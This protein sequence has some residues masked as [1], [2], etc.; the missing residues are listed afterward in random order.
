MAQVKVW[1]DNVHDYKE[2]FRERDIVIKAKQYVLMDRDEAEIFQGTYNGRMKDHGDQDDPKGFK[3]IRIDASGVNAEPPKEVFVCHK[4]GKKFDTK[5]ELDAHEKQYA[6]QVV[7]DDAI[8]QE[9]K[10]RG[11]PKKVA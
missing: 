2:K 6:D 8:E 7:K 1:N 3:M 5:A 9:I 4:D 10:R 11:R